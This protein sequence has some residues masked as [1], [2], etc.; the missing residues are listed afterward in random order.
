MFWFR[1]HST[2][3]IQIPLDV[4]GRL[5]VSPMPF[6]PYDRD[7]ALLKLY[8]KNRIEFVV[9]LV[10][11]SEIK[12]KARRDL[13]AIYRKN[14]MTPIHLPVADY[15]SPDMHQISKAVDTVSGY[16]R[17]GAHV[18]VHCN[19][20]VGR[21]GVMVSCIVRDITNMPAKDTMDYVRQFMHTNMTDEQKRLIGRFN[22]LNEVVEAKAKESVSGAT[23][24]YQGACINAKSSGDRVALHG[25]VPAQVTVSWKKRDGST[26][27][28]AVDLTPPTADSSA[29][30]YYL[31][32]DSN[33]VV[34][35]FF[36]DEETFRETVLPRSYRTPLQTYRQQ[37]EPLLDDRKLMRR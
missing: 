31:Q 18:T 4:E 12:L 28:N 16:L 3:F 32:I 13:L 27:T 25:P 1:Q 5:F 36:L 34:K 15:T 10:T 22:T 24:L 7:N 33:A 26:Y 19:A 21:S 23:V 8:K 20:G 6:G 30:T 37:G 35:A 11:D 17:A 29:G 14:S 9:V 2:N